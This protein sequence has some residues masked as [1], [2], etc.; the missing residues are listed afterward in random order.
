M[1]TADRLPPRALVIVPKSVSSQWLA[2]LQQWLPQ[3]MLAFANQTGAGGFSFDYTYF[4][5]G[6][7]GGTP[8][9]SQYAQ[10]NGWRAILAALQ[11]QFEDPPSASHTVVSSDDAMTKYEHATVWIASAAVI[12]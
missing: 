3:T 11:V 10:W 2:E 4:E 6:K 1:P 7:P 9:E 8:W 5:Q 12:R